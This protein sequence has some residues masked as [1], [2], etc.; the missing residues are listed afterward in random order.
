MDAR[1]RL[2]AT[3]LRVTTPRLAILRAL[4]QAG[5]HVT[6]E[7]VTLTVRRERPISTQ[8]VYDGLA[9]LT[10][11]GLIRRFEPAGHPA[12]YELRVGDD[13]RHFVCRKCG[14]IID[15][16]CA[17]DVAVC[18]KESEAAGFLVQEIE[19]T[20]WGL[21]EVCHREQN[22]SAEPTAP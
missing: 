19:V 1:G 5:P 14:R 7:A 20:V 11:A 16:E 18:Q 17:V 12:L 10:K 3:G 21:C 22:A 9:A 2:R 8:A 6:A 4:R 13:H 15:M